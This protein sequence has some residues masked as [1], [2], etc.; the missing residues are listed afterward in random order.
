M[1]PPNTVRAVSAIDRLM[2]SL[3]VLDEEL[4]EYVSYAMIAGLMRRLP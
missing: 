3:R 4:A 2:L 1:Q